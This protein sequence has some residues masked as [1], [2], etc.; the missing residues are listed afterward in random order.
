MLNEQI[1]PYPVNVGSQIQ[2]ALGVLVT[3]L[4]IQLAIFG[5]NTLTH[6]FLVVFLVVRENPVQV[7][8][9]Q[10]LSQLVCF[11]YARCLL[12]ILF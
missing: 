7:K 12:T 5:K 8:D 6:D 10:R 11:H 1:L 3:R 2:T 9:Q 4:C